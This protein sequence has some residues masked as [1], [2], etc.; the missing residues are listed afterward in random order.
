MKRLLLLVALSAFGSVSS[1]SY[2]QKVKIP[3]LTTLN[4][5]NDCPDT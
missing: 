5:I 4:D 2:A 1:T 3:C